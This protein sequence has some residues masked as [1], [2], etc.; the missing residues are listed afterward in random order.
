[1]SVLLELC[2]LALNPHEPCPV[3]SCSCTACPIAGFSCMF[4]RSADAL[5]YLKEWGIEEYNL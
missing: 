1:M 2:Q 5:A 3:V 4:R